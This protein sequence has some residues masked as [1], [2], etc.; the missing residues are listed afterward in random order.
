MS[1]AQAEATPQP[2]KLQMRSFIL[3]IV[4]GLVAATAASFF[5]WIVDGGQEVVYKKLPEAF[6]WD[7]LPGWWVLLLLIVGA[8]LV[9]VARRLPGATGGSPL[10]GFHFTNPISWAPGILVAAFGTLVFGAA[11]GPEGPLI[12]L[13]SAI[14]TWHCTISP[15]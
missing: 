6:G 13:G 15:P 11:L 12:V 9:F 10:S 5:L 2:L 4:V 14:V 3:A 1:Q 7:A 8:A